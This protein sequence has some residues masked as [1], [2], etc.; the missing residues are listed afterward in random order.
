MPCSGS[1]SAQANQFSR[2]RGSTTST[3]PAQHA[4]LPAYRS[5]PSFVQGGG[6]SGGEG[7]GEGE[8]D[9]DG[10]DGEG[11]GS[12]V[13]GEGGGGVARGG[14]SLACCA[15]P[16]RA[17]ATHA[18]SRATLCRNRSHIFDLQDPTRPLQPRVQTLFT[19][20]RHAVHW[21]ATGG[22][23][24]KVSLHG[25]FRMPVFFSVLKCCV[26]SKKHRHAHPLCLY[27]LAFKSACGSVDASNSCLVNLAD[28]GPPSRRRRKT[29][30][31][32]PYKRHYFLHSAPLPVRGMPV[33]NTFPVGN[34]PVSYQV[35]VR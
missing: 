7:G 22:V 21:T 12:G 1:S 4:P 8:G 9:G 31:S 29:C 2:S 30:G 10:G 35:P 24:P 26:A 18:R 19:A 16:C 20:D 34:M 11:G 27:T 28:P 3:S 33:G 6:A 14:S 25:R 17:L 15:L 23:E 5:V 13:S 32:C